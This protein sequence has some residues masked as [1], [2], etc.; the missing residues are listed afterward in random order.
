[1]ANDWRFERS[2][3][4][5]IGGLRAYAGV[6]LRFQTEFGE[7]VAF[8]SLCVASNSPEELL[9]QATQQAL[10]RLA[11]WIVADIVHSARARRQRERRRMLELLSRAQRR[12]DERFDME[13]EIPK[14]LREVY[15]GTEVSIVRT[16]DGRVVLEEGASFS[17]SDLE[18]GLWED[19][20]CFDYSIEKLNHLDLTAPRAVRAVVA[21]CTS[22]IVP[23]F[24]VVACKDFKLVF[25]DAD[26]WFAQM[27]AVSSN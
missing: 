6:P 18:Q 14:I 19:T 24:L 11:D 2:P 22:Q 5:E 16:M 9:S 17:T 15:P 21:Q 20:G 8:G 1:M 7:H 4:V 12:C 25:D 13:Q 23:T 3:H 10:V 27:C 26:S